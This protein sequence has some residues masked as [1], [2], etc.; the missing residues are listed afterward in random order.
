MRTTDMA[1]TMSED[2]AL[3]EAF[4]LTEG[5]G[6]I[7]KQVALVAL[8]VVFLAV[9]SKIRVPFWPVPL[10]MQ[11]FGTLLVGAAFGFRLGGLTLLA[12]LAV[13]AAGVSVFNGDAAGLAYF[14]GPTGGYLVGFAVAGAL[15]GWLAERGWSRSVRGMVGALLLGNIVIYAFGVPWMAYLFLAERGADWVIQYSFTNFL[16]GDAVKL[17]LAA[18]MLPAAW[19]L[20]GR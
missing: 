4:G 18:V 12:W 13:G 9:M 14:A 20:S 5:R 6:R 15:V 17:A 16:L 10:T 3:A 7:A 8:G 1:V 19:K 11:T 2:R